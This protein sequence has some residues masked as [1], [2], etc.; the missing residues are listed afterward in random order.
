MVSNILQLGVNVG[1]CEAD[2]LSLVKQL[3]ASAVGSVPTK[4]DPQN[5]ESFPLDSDNEES[6]E[7]L[8][9]SAIKEVC[10]ELMDEVYDEEIIT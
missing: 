5:F 8:E 9:K 3:S 7:E 6:L 4:T 2:R 1:S 10:G